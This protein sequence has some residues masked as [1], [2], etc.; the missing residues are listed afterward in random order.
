[1]PRYMLTI[2]YDGTDFCGWQKQEPK[3]TDPEDGAEE[4]HAQLSPALLMASDRPGRLALRTVQGVVEQAVRQVVR[5]PIQLIGASRT[6]SGVHARGQVAAFT[7]EPRSP[8]GDTDA[9]EAPGDPGAARGIGWP[10]ERG[11]D[12]LVQA[13]NSRLPADVLVGAAC[14][15]R[16]NFDPIGD[17]VAKEYTYTF[18]TGP[19]RPVFDRRVVHHVRHGT[20][21]TIAMRAGAA[22]LVGEHDFGAFAA[23][24]HGRLS[25]VRTVHACTIE[26]DAPGPDGS[27]LVRLRIQGNGF[28]WN[29]VRIIAGTLL[30]IGLGRLPEGCIV[31]GLQT[32]DRRVLG[33][34]IP[35]TGLCLEW[36]RYAEHGAD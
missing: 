11:C 28:L 31:A 21:N 19:A 1:M 5:E 17:A 20:L 33:P 25:T 36:V 16:P 29:M 13:I 27:R 18:H 24:G 35:P 4:G 32:G 9:A 26:E 23:A 3:A 30:E 14:V 8:G 2:A 10:I 22:A 34:T 15:A 6:D 7:C 12:R